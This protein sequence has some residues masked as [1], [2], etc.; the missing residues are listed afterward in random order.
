MSYKLKIKITDDILQ[1]SMMCGLDGRTVSN[2][3]AFAVAV[4]EIFPNANVGSTLILPDGHTKPGISFDIPQIMTDFIKTFDSLRKTPWKRLE[5]PKEE[6]ELE[7]PQD[8]IDMINIDEVKETLKGVQH[9]ELIE[10]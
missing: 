4:R 10:N 6:F 7:I 5:L 8:I 1:R 2:N 3:C 9:L